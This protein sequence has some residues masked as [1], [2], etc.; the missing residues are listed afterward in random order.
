MNTKIKIM[1]RNPIS[2]RIEEV[3]PED[4]ISASEVMPLFMGDDQR[5]YSVPDYPIEIAW[6]EWIAQNS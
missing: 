1:A 6:S 4:E 5:W 2:R 3:H